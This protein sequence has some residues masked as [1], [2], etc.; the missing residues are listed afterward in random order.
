MCYKY[1]CW[2][3]FFVCISICSSIFVYILCLTISL[4]ESVSFVFI[5][6][7]IRKYFMKQDAFPEC[8][9]QQHVLVGSK[10]WELRVRIAEVEAWRVRR[11][12]FLANTVDDRGCRADGRA[13]ALW[14]IAVIGRVVF[15]DCHRLWRDAGA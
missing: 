8:R 13:I 7:L 10:V 5:F 4:D 14:T 12:K 11:L 6:V 15:E 2:L 9:I 3:V 1:V